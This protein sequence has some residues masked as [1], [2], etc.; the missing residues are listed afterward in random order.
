MRTLLTAITIALAAA[1]AAGC[2]SGSS[3]GGGTP[4]T[5]SI[6]HATGANDVLVD[7]HAGIGAFTP[8]EYAIDDRPVFRLYG[9]GTVVVRGDDD[10]VL[11]QPWTYRLSE[12]GVD[13]VLDAAADAGLLDGPVDY[14]EPNITDVGSTSVAV[15]A[16]GETHGH[17]AYALGYEN[18]TADGLTAA[19]R[20]ARGELN[21]F[22]DYV[23]GLPEEHAELLLD[24][25]APLAP[26]AIEVHAWPAP[27]GSEVTVTD[28]PISTPLPGKAVS[29]SLVAGCLTL[30]GADL[31]AVEEALAGAGRTLWRSD[32]Q[33]WAAGYRIVLPGETPCDAQAEPAGY[34][35]PPAA[36]AALEPLPGDVF[37]EPTDEEAT[38]AE[39]AIAAHL[40]TATDPREAEV[41]EQLATYTRQYVGI[42][43]DGRRLVYANAFCDD[44]GL[45]PATE[46]VLVADG[47]TCFWQAVVD[48]A[49]G[50]IVSLTINGE[51]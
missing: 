45:E 15:T 30:R 38:A 29:D 20:E 4:G 47:G 6:P 19:Q 28:W 48:P 14:G 49:T 9:D 50:E 42:D 8:P 2:G 26:E 32:G 24:A 10:S 23:T 1:V 21:G 43:R 27:D 7:V 3:G 36:W 12:E 5:T 39:A 18:E 51:A 11:P 37:V 34:R 25:P 33:L 44:A 16:A 40:S 46:L 35:L 41:A 22:I 17:D 31:A 13:A